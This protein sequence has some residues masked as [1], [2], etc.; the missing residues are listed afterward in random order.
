MEPYPGIGQEVLSGGYQDGSILTGP[1]QYENSQMLNNSDIVH[2][3][4]VSQ[5]KSTGPGFYERA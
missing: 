4:T 5:V 2:F 3:D 1:S